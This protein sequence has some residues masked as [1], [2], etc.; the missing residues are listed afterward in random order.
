[1]AFSDSKKTKRQVALLYPLAIPH[2]T[3]FVRGVMDY[4]E[5]HGGWSLTTSPPALIGAGEQ[6]LRLDELHGWP[7]DGVLAA[8]L[9]RKEIRSAQ[10][11]G[12]PVLNMASTLRETGIPRVRPD[13]YA[14]GRMAA[15]HLLQRGLTRLAYYGLAGFLVFPRAVPWIRRVRQTGWSDVRGVGSASKIGALGESAETQRIAD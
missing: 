5:E 8:I 13:H 6:A 9:N 12:I 10:R 4:A 14:M 11:L 15:E 3:M 2:M 1:M 7:G